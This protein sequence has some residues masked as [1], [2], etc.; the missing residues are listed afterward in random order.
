MDI[1]KNFSDFFKGVGLRG[2]GAQGERREGGKN[3]LSSSYIENDQ[4][5]KNKQNLQKYFSPFFDGG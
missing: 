5:V 3:V 1:F 2:S 4:L